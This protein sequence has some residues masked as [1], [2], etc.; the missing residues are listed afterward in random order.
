[1]KSVHHQTGSQ[2][3]QKMTSEQAHT[4]AGRRTTGQGNPLWRHLLAC[5]RDKGNW[6]LK[7]ASETAIAAAYTFKTP[8]ALQRKPGR[9]LACLAQTSIRSRATTDTLVSTC[10]LV[11]SCAI[12]NSVGACMLAATV[13][14][15]S[16]FRET[17][18]PS[19][20]ARIIGVVEIQ[21]RL[22][23]GSLRLIHLSFGR[24][25][26]RLRHLQ[27]SFRGVHGFLRCLLR[28]FRGFFFGGR[29]IVSVLSGFKV[30]L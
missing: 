29:G 14:P 21:L 25:Q 3:S 24:G 27:S 8:N 2:S 18:T 26:L 11:R 4:K 19:T 9:G 30:F 28:R 10:I 20:G 23:Q 15:T 1:M 7:M 12:R 17:T 22:F 13:C 6:F 16:T 5:Y